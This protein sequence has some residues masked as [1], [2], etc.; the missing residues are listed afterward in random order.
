[1]SA[2]TKFVKGA[3]ALVSN[4]L[5][6]LILSI[7]TG[8]FAGVVVTFYNICVSYGEQYSVEIYA[9][10]L[11]SPALIPLLFLWLAAGAV[12]IGTMVKFIPMIRGSGIPQIEGAARGTL[13]FSW[14]VTLCSMFAASLACV[15]LGLSAG[16][17]GPSLEIGGCCG[18]AT[19]R[20]FRRSHMTRRLQIASGS[21][22]GLAVAFNAPIT[23][24]I[25]ALEEAFRSFSAQVFICS[26]VSVGCALVVRNAIRSA[27]GFAVS[28]AF[29]GFA[30]N[31]FAAGEYLY[32][33]SGALVCALLGVIFYYGV[34]GAKKLFKKIKFFGGTG[35]FFIPFLLAGVFGL[36]SFYAM[37]GGHSF[38]DALATGGTGEFSL[39]EIFGAGV[40]ATIITVTAMK[41]ITSITAMGCG[42]PC[43]VFI[44]MLAVGAGAGG[45]LS[46]VFIKCG[47][48]P[49]IAD[50]LVV[51]CM[52]A[53][54]T[55]VVKA[56]ITGL[57]MAFEL[58]GQFANALPVLTGVTVGYLVSELFRTQPIYEKSLEMFTEEEGCNRNVR[59][60]RVRSV[61]CPDSVADGSRVRKIIWPTDGLVVRV[62]RADGTVIVPD[63]ETQLNAGDVIVFECETSNRRAL[64]A[65][66]SDIT[67]DRH[68][69]NVGGEGRKPD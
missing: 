5:N 59:R 62:T 23:G 31:S 14:Y 47:M 35:K 27:L 16:G 3:K 10:F 11:N 56:P 1:M 64:A 45:A 18:E 49:A 42:V 25:F 54:F 66:I 51:I 48:N 26:A 58:T 65:Y 40:L 38:I 15:F 52:S 8:I 46:F 17:E 20:L 44:P 34:M 9:A 55:S 36:V 69:E 37:G 4:S 60:E 68:V 63:G 30:F 53:F 21:S 32:V 41:F 24:M 22:A 6:L 33:L 50:Y 13:A 29:E 12:I 57:V 19:G 43:G 7:I 67:G 61:V 39:D 28:F 2:K